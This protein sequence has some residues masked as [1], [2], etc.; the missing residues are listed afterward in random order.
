ML[1][2]RPGQDLDGIL[3]FL[4]ENTVNGLCGVLVCGAVKGGQGYKPYVPSLTLPGHVCPADCSFHLIFPLAP[5]SSSPLFSRELLPRPTR[6]VR[7]S[8]PCECDRLSP[9]RPQRT[10]ASRAIGEQIARAD[11]AAASRD[12]ARNRKARAK[13]WLIEAVRLPRPLSSHLAIQRGLHFPGRGPRHAV[14][15]RERARGQAGEPSGLCRDPHDCEFRP[16]F[17]P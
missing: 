7:P 2:P 1:R 17:R 15:P 10:V 13:L 4:K 11:V 3:R 6:P 16:G 8:P 12:T 9:L 5:V 14:Q